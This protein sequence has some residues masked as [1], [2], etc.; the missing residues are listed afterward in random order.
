[1]RPA[2]ASDPT[3]QLIVTVTFAVWALSEIVQAT[4]R[5]ANAA[6]ADRFSLLVLRVCITIGVVLAVVALRDRAAAIADSPALFGVGL[7]ALWCGI[8]LRWWSFLTLGRYFTFSVMTSADQPVITSG[9]YRVLRHPS[10]AGMLLGLLGVGV[11]FGNWLSLAALLA[12]SGAA[13]LYRIHVEE[14]ALS[15]SLGPRYT[16]YA[17]GRKRL[18]PF[19]W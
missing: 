14:H 5:R 19:I 15:S 1:V 4:R 18:L 9:P 11:L 12:C 17:Q 3:L 6:S 13:I 2:F 8:V 16:S 10:Y 7:L